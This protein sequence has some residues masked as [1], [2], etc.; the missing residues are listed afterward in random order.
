[1]AEKRRRRT[2]PDAEE[3]LPEKDA[4][5]EEEAPVR[6]RAR[7]K[8][9]AEEP[10]E[11]ED[12]YGVFK[13]DTEA[14]YRDEDEDE[15]EEEEA[16]RRRSRSKAASGGGSR[17]TRARDEEE[18]EDEPEDEEEDE[19]GQERLPLKG[20]WKQ[21]AKIRKESANFP[22]EFT[23]TD[24]EQLVKFLDDEPFVTYR[25][26]WFNEI[27]QGQKGYMCL[28]EDCP[29][30]EAGDGSPAVKGLFN[31]VVF[32][33]DGNAQVKVLSAGS[34][35]GSTLEAI[36]NSKKGPLT[37]HYYG[38]SKTGKKQNTTY[39]VTPY[40]ERDVEDEWRIEP[41]GREEIKQFQKQKYG[42]EYYE[43]KR[44][45]RKE[46]RDVVRDLAGDE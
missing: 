37:K 4:E 28:G 8:R 42:A 15:E 44:P 45:S 17:R 10:P 20:G 7:P 43:R 29:A 12:A 40:R 9:P 21:F 3:Y 2:P 18:D 22:D 39:V 23:P 24:D 25:L 16:P 38:V 1:M 31:V 14:A 46:L 11:D 34:R 35:L 6:R 5:E 26:H 13:E 33:E 27:R 19:G 36:A 30:C 32:D 41:L